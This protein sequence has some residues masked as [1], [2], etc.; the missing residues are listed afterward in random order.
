MFSRI[1]ASTKRG[2]AAA[3]VADAPTAA[4]AMRQGLIGIQA[5]GQQLSDD[6]PSLSDTEQQLSD[7]EQPQPSDSE[8][9]ATLNLVLDME[10]LQ[11][12]DHSVVLDL[13]P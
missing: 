6:E 12:N 4:E 8:G 5:E 11:S 7:T 9:E 1:L 3:A 13:T 10:R 2:R